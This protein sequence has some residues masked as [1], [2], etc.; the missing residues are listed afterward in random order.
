M[1]PDGEFF[2][3]TIHEEPTPELYLW[4]KRFLYPIEIIYPGNA[5]TELREYFSSL[6]KGEAPDEGLYDMI[7]SPFP[8]DNI[9]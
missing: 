1:S 7:K 8:Y 3:A 5:E 2:I 9:R 4:A 6:A